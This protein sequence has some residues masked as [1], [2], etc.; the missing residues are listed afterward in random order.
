MMDEVKT[1]SGVQAKRI[2]N[3]KNLLLLC[4]RGNKE[5]LEIVYVWIIALYVLKPVPYDMLADEY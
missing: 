1:T 3:G 4:I 2:F 5:F